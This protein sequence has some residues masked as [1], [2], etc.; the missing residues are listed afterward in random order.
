MTETDREQY[1]RAE[2][3]ALAMGWNDTVALCA[4]SGND[5]FAGSI[6]FLSISLSAVVLNSAKTS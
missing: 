3:Q 4:L 5:A 2:Q 1:R 6:L